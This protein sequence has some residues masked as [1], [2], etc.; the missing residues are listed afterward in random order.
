MPLNPVRTSL[1]NGATLL[2][3][4]TTTTPAVAISVAIRAGS[5][6]DP[7]GMPGMTS[8]LARVID[9]GTATRS[10]ADIAEALDS[11]GITLTT[12][13][14][15]HLFSITCSC[16]AED[17]EPVLALLGDVLMAPSLPEDEIATRKGEAITAV[18]QDDD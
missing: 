9:R 12:T 10:A 13:V 8:L 1:D 6:A 16:L 2:V 7:G 3:K 15:R 18:R 4:Q 11:R 17:F 5:I 14:T